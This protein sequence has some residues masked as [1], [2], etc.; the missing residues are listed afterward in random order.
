MFS[1]IAHAVANRRT[2]TLILI[3]WLVAFVLSFVAPRPPSSTQQQDFLPGSDDSIVAAHIASNPA[4]F[5]HTGTQ[6]A[7]P[8]IVIFRNAAGLTPDNIQRAQ[9]VSDYLDNPRQRPALV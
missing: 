7:L 1:A 5:P 8:L 2:A 4:K 6:Q 9:T 3:A